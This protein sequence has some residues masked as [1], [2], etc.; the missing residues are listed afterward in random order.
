MNWTSR[1]LLIP[2]LMIISMFIL[3]IIGTMALYSASDGVW[4]MSVKQH[5]IRSAIGFL[6]AFL[7]LFFRLIGCL[8][9][10]SSYGLLLSVF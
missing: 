5:L 7:S 3:V 8:E 4:T 2:W 9:P 6:I 10:V 1:L